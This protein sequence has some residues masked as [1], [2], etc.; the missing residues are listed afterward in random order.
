MDKLS[1]DIST[2]H[3]AGNR[4]SD[5][6]LIE[7]LFPITYRTVDKSSYES[8]DLVMDLSKPIPSGL[9]SSF[10]FVYTGGCL[11]NVFSPADVLIN[12]SRLLNDQGRVL[13]LNPH[14][15][16]LALFSYVTAEWFLSYYA[17]NN[18]A[19][20]KVY[21][22]SQTKPGV[23]RFDYDVHIF[24]YSHNFTPFSKLRLLRN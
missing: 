9:E 7:S 14:L 5:R 10:D 12:S 21:L 1:L 20:C 11:D 15:G 4:Y 8:A 6:S 3:G 13:P 2:R 18:F 22:L 23:S 19:D 17:A 24:N 16:C